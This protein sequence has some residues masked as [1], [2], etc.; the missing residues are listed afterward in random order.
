M[1]RQWRLRTHHAALALDAVEQRGLLAADVGAGTNTDLD[2]EGLARAEHVGAEHGGSA[3]RGDRL[4][5][6]RDRVRVLGANV[7]VAL[8]RLGCETSDG[9]ALDQDERIALHDHAVGERAR[10]ALVGVADDVLL[11]ARRVEHGAP[12]DARWKTCAAA[13][14]E[15]RVGDGCDDVGRG[16]R[17]R[18]LEA[19]ETAVGLVI[20]ER[21]GVGNAAAR[22]GEARLAGK[23][24]DLLGGAECECVRAAIEEVGIEQRGDVGDRDG[25]IGNAARWR[26]DLDERLKPVHATR[27]VAHHAGIEAARDDLVGDGGSNFVRAESNRGGVARNVDADGH[28]VTS[29]TRAAT[30]SASMRPITRDSSRIAAG[31]HEQRPRQKIGSSVSAPS[32]VVS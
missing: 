21:D 24:R 9:H 13:A 17:N 11:L 29:A 10:V 22:K 3:R 8:G 23:E 7:D 18:G 4:F 5:H 2:V 25:A 14:A 26:V 12:L 31:A 30:L 28:A 27:A 32:A 6:R 19:N 1:G 16:H 20:G 15:A